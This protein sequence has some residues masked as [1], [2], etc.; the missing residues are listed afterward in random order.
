MSGLDFDYFYLIS[1]FLSLGLNPKGKSFNS[2]SNTYSIKKKTEDFSIV[3]YLER[4]FKAEWFYWLISN[5]V[6][7]ITECL[8]SS[9]S[10]QRR[11]WISLELPITGSTVL[12]QAAQ[13]VNN[14]VLSFEKSKLMFLKKIEI[15]WKTTFESH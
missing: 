5:Q 10:Q 11:F 2:N 15:H 7:S 13:M 3:A 14:I 4:Y 9:N 12:H 1:P 6:C 8:S